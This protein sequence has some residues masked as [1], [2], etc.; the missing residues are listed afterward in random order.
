MK[1]KKKKKPFKSGL[2]INTVRGIITHPILNVPAFVFYEDDSYVDCRKC[3]VV[4]D[5]DNP[6]T[7]TLAI[8]TDH[9]PG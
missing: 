1:V 3:I 8:P 2:L 6:E 9:S 5:Y 7:G 4:E